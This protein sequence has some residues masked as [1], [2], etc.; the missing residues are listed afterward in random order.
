MNSQNNQS[1]QLSPLQKA[2][3]AVKEMRTKLE[4][5][6]RL[7]S[8]P[9]AIV[10]MGCRFPG[11]I[12]SPAAFW[13]GLCQGI[14]AIT[15][16]PEN[17]WNIDAYY[18]NNPDTPGKSYS[19]RGGFIDK[20][21]EFDG[22]FFG[23]SP[24]EINPMDPQQRLLLEV[25]WE[26]LEN[27]AIAPST[28]MGSQTGVFLG[29][30]VNEYGHGTVGGNPDDIDVYTAT[31]NAL[32][33]AAG[34]I[35]HYYGFHG[36]SLV[37]DTA[38]SSSLVAIHLACQS[39]RKQ[40]C[41]MALTGGS[42][43]MLS[44]NTLVS[45]AK[46]KALSPDGYCK[47]FDATADGYVR[48]EGCGLVVLKRLS[49][50]VANGDNLLGVIRGTAM[51]QDGRSSG[52]TVPNG[53]AQQA[54][55]RAA[56][57]DGQVDPSQVNYIETHGT[58]TSLGDPIEAKA[59]TDVFCGDERETALTLGSVKT[60]IGHLEAA[61]GVASLIKVVL[62][63][64]N[65]QITPHLHLKQLNPLLEGLPIHIP[66][67]PTPWDVKEG[68]KR[69]AGVSS[70]GF[71]GTNAHLIIEE[72]NNE[73]AEGRRQ[74]AEGHFLLP[75]SAKSSRGLKDLAKNYHNFLN[76]HAE[77][78]LEDLFYTA[79][80][81]R[82]HFNYR[83]ATVGNTRKDLLQELSRFDTLEQTQPYKNLPKIAF[84]FTGQ[85]SQYLN[86]G[87]ELYQNYSV[88]RETLNKCNDIL[89]AYLQTP[90]LEVLYERK[91]QNLL[92][93]TI[94]TQPAL[95]SLEYAL[96]KLW[97]SWGVEPDIMMGHSVGEY[98]A[99]CVAGIFSLEDALKLI[100][101]RGRLMNNLP[102]NGSMV[103]VST[104][105]NQV[106]EIIANS[107]SQVSIAAING[108]NQV[109]ISGEREA[110]SNIVSK[111]EREGIETKILQVSHAFH[112]PLMEPIL[113][114][115][116]QVAQEIAYYQPK[117][118]IISNLGEPL[119]NMA[120]AN[121][122]CRH[123]MEKVQFFDGIKTLENQDY[124]LFLEIGATP[125]LTKMGQRCF[126]DF[127]NRIWLSS[128]YPKQSDE[129]IILES[130]KSLYCQ[131]LDIDWSNFYKSKQS[132]EITYRK[133]TL[134]TYPFQRQKYWH[135]EGKS[136]NLESRG[137]V[138]LSKNII[139]PLLDRR[140]VS[141]LKAIQ[142]QSIINLDRLPLVKD[143][144]ING[145]PLMNL[146]IYLEIVSEGIKE[147]WD[148]SMGE[149]K[150]LKI[151]EALTFANEKSH[152][153]QLILSSEDEK[154]IKFQIFSQTDVSQFDW[155]LHA[156]GTVFLDNLEISKDSQKNLNL[157]CISDI[158]YD[159]IPKDRFYK[160][161]EEK[162]IVLG[163]SCQQIEQIWR[164]DQ[165]AI[166]SINPSF[167]NPYSLPLG[168]IDAWIQLLLAIFHQD[169][170]TY[171]LIGLESF[172]SYSLSH[173]TSHKSNTPNTP[174]TPLYWGHA[175]LT[176]N[177]DQGETVFGHLFLYDD[178]GNLIAEISNAELKRVKFE[179]NRLKKDYVGQKLQKITRQQLLK[180]D[181][182]DCKALIA[183]YI[184][185][186]LARS[187]QV[188]PTQIDTEQSLINLLDSLI[189]MELRS[190]LERDL[191]LSASLEQLLG[192]RNIQQLANSLQEQI[193]ITQMTTSTPETG[194]EDVEEMTL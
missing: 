149:V 17:R 5:M 67:H 113:K 20:V 170:A 80:V 162:G 68:Q 19:K 191:G 141:P 71:S 1:K 182:R 70:F 116:F 24:R 7:Q 104:S 46:M 31:G 110:I 44:P 194:D 54:C 174:C 121:Y 83:F 63:L 124:K 11:G 2:A 147:V 81:G 126:E 32:S 41:D 47:T 172:R 137:K 189:A 146:V 74:E 13:E 93:Q 143:H 180:A 135:D 175:K 35:S 57:K 42:F 178:D 48:G 184:K 119:E 87:H 106:K 45:V 161:L 84:L 109:V 181:S 145:I 134:P 148:Q 112:S 95:F 90:L 177:R 101:Y 29:I 60:N 10:G 79:A 38:C 3:L 173:F 15:D 18:D 185:Q 61:A 167:P 188:S 59:L 100:A 9:I 127:S 136:L 156:V 34:R 192:D 176:D 97:E 153:I 123:I 103:A 4:K 96:V 171:L 62:G 138:T 51:N 73:K 125:T 43:L 64:Q 168:E 33:I 179:K 26:A 52:L 155:K 133:I 88:F 16:I 21:D 89:N 142:F 30:S 8:E 118:D 65:K 150:D 114:D 105:E 92:K 117:I 154:N 49:D 98:V 165:E 193:T 169:S 72:W 140:I 86:M 36:P 131:G 85:G 183:T 91:D 14:D 37:I 6:E 50:A 77:I 160:N 166:A 107:N 40:E 27:A 28:L 69:M 55:I 53:Q 111:L 128:L 102:Q 115:F 58:G 75:L 129:S 76:H 187:L 99:A 39:L 56:L 144:C 186:T 159:I 190:H 132:E 82:D 12:N 22:A 151:I 66:T 25:S 78:N 130:L 152:N 122:W 158:N 23:L 120:N 108:P 157:A 139:S 94:Y 163:S 164:K